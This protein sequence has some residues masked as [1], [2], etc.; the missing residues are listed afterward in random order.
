MS[1]ASEGKLIAPKG[2]FRVIGG[3]TFEGW[4]AE[5][6][7]CDFVDKAAAILAAQAIDRPSQMEVAYVYDDAGRLV[8]SADMSEVRW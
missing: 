7:E 6:L 8:W 3:D 1:L 2:K 4:D 5:W